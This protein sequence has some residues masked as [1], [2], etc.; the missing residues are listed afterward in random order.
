MFDVPAPSSV[1]P[2]DVLAVYD[3]LGRYGHLIDERAYERLVEVF[4]EDCVYDA[5]D[6]GGEVL[7]GSAA[8]VEQ[9]RTSDS[10]PLAHHAT[11]ILV[12]ANPDGTLAVLSKGIGVGPRGRVGSVVYEDTARRTAAGWRLAARRAVLRRPGA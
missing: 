7:H 6:F 1:P 5:T 2:E 8:V 9:M 4:T 11:N 3:L 10:H 12:A